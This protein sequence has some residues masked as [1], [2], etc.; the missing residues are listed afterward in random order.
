MSILFKDFEMRK[1]NLKQFFRKNVKK[2]MDFLY[3]MLLL[4]ILKL[5]LFKIFDISCT[6]LKFLCKSLIRQSRNKIALLKNKINLKFD[7]KAG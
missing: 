4:S 1:E 2:E 3:K 7:L 6:F 5:N